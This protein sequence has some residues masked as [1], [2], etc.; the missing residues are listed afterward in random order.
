MLVQ[1]WIEEHLCHRPRYLNCGMTGLECI[2]KHE[3]RVGGYES[4]D[5]TEAWHAHLR[6]LTANKIEWTF[7]WL[8]VDEVIYMSAEVCFLLLM[9]LRGI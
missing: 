4:P 9:G 3:K 2:E 1:L 7:G 8:S 5:G 6:S